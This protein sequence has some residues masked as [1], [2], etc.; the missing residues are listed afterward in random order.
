MSAKLHFDKWIKFYENRHCNQNYY[1]HLHKKYDFYF[2]TIIH[3]LKNRSLEGLLYTDSAL[4]ELGGGPQITLNAL[5]PYLAD[6]D[7]GLNQYINYDLIKYPWHSDTVFDSYSVKYRF[8]QA[9]FLVLPKSLGYRILYEPLI[10]SH[11][12]L[13]HYDPQ[14]IK[15]FVQELHTHNP[16]AKHVHYVPGML[17]RKPSFGDEILES[18][19]YWLNIFR[20]SYPHTQV[21]PF[22]NFYDYLIVT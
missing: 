12:V 17:Y 9:D 20:K 4:I 1:D 3:K 6:V 16:T 15:W 2:K 13:E 11:G 19:L 18:P 14:E 22:N 8:S 5:K 10:V 7:T 21:I